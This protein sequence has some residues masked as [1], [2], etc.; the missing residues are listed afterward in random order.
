MCDFPMCTLIP[1]SNGFCH[2]HQV[3]SDQPVRV[4]SNYY[5]TPAPVLSASERADKRL[6]DQQQAYLIAHPD[7]AMKRPGCT[8]NATQVSQLLISKTADP[9]DQT[10]WTACCENC[11]SKTIIKL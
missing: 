8:G 5:A 1:E 9:F 4:A 3:Y 2:R 10:E 7:C 6:R 11:R